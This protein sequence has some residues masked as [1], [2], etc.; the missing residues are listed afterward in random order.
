M[1]DRTQ[2]GVLLL[3]FEKKK[4]LKTLIIV[5]ESIFKFIKTC[6]DDQGWSVVIRYEREKRAASW[7][8]RDVSQR[9]SVV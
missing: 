2:Y 9:S 5:E 4:V 8:T 6:R 1:K 7:K 3:T